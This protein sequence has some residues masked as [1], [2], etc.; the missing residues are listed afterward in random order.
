MKPVSKFSKHYRITI[1][2]VD[3]MKKLKVS[4]AF[5][6]FQEIAGLHA[7]NLGI[8]FKTLEQKYGVFWVLTRMRVDFLRYPIWDEEIIVE[9]WPQTPRKY[10]CTRDYL[11]KDCNGNI[12]SRA[13]S[14]W[15][16]LDIK[17][18][19]LRKTDLI[20]V[21]FPKIIK[22]RAI[23]CTLG[24][25]KLPQEPKI[26]YKR[27]IGCSDIDINCHLNNCKY[28]DF[29]MDCFSME[30][31]KKYHA[32]SIQVNYINEAFPGNTIVL[33]KC[34]SPSEA[35]RLYI[36]GV[37]EEDNSTFFISQIEIEEN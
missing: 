15:V 13:V 18:R 37:N 6:Y 5:N 21:H 35:N 28:L 2:D 4:A 34:T 3:F 29:I 26:A 10:S 17:T 33:Y 23:D 9:T 36:E 22:E 11:M 1:S 27:V 31:L 16:M 14:Q 12:I 32:K 20:A 24:K 7:E 25:V 8:G 30:E 19:K